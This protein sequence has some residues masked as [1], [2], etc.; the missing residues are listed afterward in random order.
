MNSWLFFSNERVTE[1]FLSSSN[2]LQ[3]NCIQKAMG[4]T[5]FKLNPLFTAVNDPPG[6]RNIEKG[7]PL[8]SLSIKEPPT[9]LFKSSANPI[10]Q[11]T[12]ELLTVPLKQFIRKHTSFDNAWTT[13]LKSEAIAACSFKDLE[14]RF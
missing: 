10:Q 12:P 13:L 7:S 11:P 1:Q 5:D 4:P 3:H 14:K 8:T 2:P 9:S 6:V